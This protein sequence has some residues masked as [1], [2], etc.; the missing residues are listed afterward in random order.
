M[1]KNIEIPKD[2]EL[3]LSGYPEAI[4]H[5]GALRDLVIGR[6]H[7]VKDID[8]AIPSSSPGEGALR[9]WSHNPW[10]R[11]IPKQFKEA[12]R[13][14]PGLIEVNNFSTPYTHITVQ[15]AV[16]DLPNTWFGRRIIN[17]ND[18]GINQ[19]GWDG[20]KFL[21]TSAFER[22]EQTNTFT[23]LK[24][25]VPQQAHNSIKRAK[26]WQYSG[27]YKGFKFD[28]SRAEEFLKNH[29]KSEID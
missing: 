18:F 2:E 22:D 27:D 5:G 28:V 15:I 9:G 11:Q 20:R 25:Q 21:W 16:W 13:Q 14:I 17:R 7:R 19:I 3:H 10:P 6:F 23:A 4:I 26:N 24:F 12:Y 1:F 8:I 29:A